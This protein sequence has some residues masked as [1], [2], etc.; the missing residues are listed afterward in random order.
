MPSM[1]QEMSAKM[2]ANPALK[3]DS[4]LVSIGLVEQ[5]VNT[6]GRVE[7]MVNTEETRAPAAAVVGLVFQSTLA[8]FA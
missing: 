7:Q 5:A 3:N 6:L 4:G 1:P 2:P 8:K